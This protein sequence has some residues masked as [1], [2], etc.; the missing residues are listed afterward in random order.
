MILPKVNFNISYKFEMWKSNDSQETKTKRNESKMYCLIWRERNLFRCRILSR[1]IFVS[2]S[3][4][5][6]FN[7]STISLGAYYSYSNKQWRNN[8]HTHTH[9]EYQEKG[10]PNKYTRN[11]FCLSHFYHSF[12]LNF[13]FFFCLFKLSGSRFYIFFFSKI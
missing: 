3:L 7:S 13:F 10:P 2:F 5:S 1:L 11:P 12:L 4:R 8:R 9:F 6:C